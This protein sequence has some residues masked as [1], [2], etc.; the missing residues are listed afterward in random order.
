M[1]GLELVAVARSYGPRV[2]IEGIDLR[3][4]P[5]EVTVILGHNGSGKS[6]LLR[7]AAGILRPSAGRVLLDGVDLATMAP[8]VV[9]RSIAGVAQEESVDFPYTVRD[10]ASLG[11]HPHLGPF[12]R[13]GVEDRRAVES[14]LE[15]LDLVALADRPVPE[16]SGGERR[17]AFLA[18]ALAQE[19]TVLLLDEPT[20][21]LD[22][23]HEAAL[24]AVIRTLARTRRVAVALALHDLNLVGLVA[25]RVVLLKD[26]R[27]R[28]SGAPAEV[29]DAA[30][31]SEAY[32]APVVTVP[33]P[34]GGAPL[35]VPRGAP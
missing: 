34:G 16:L 35:V 5:G 12:A 25:D 15:A 7:V 26:G 17:R 21:H 22:L 23:G 31:L 20:A 28:A 30:T 29:L 14:A 1:A 33:R 11:R 9:A 6:T 4:V 3:L 13:E 18:R 19:P 27:I 2:A 32:G 24:L 8:R 10:V